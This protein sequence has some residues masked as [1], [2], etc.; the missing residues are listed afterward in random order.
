MAT[1]LLTASSDGLRLIIT[2]R[3]LPPYGYGMTEPG[4]VTNCL[5]KKLRPRSL[6]CGSEFPAGEAELGIGTLEALKLIT[7]GGRVP[8]G[9]SR[10]ISC[11]AA[12]TCAVSRV[13]TGVRLEVDFDDCQTV[14]AHQ[15]DVLNVVD[16][17]VNERS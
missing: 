2:C 11:D 1:G 17:R 10:N 9:N 13:N 6:S 16:Q 14:I 4:T 7:S 3:C 8:G 12:V 5:R 15:L